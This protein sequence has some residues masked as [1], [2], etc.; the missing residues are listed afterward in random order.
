MGDEDSYKFA[1]YHTAKQLLA[2]YA[3]CTVYPRWVL[4]KNLWGVFQ[5]T[6]EPREEDGEIALY[7]IDVR[8]VAKPGAPKGAPKEKIRT[9]IR[10]GIEDVPFT[11]LRGANVGIVPWC[12]VQRTSDPQERFL[13]EHASE[14]SRYMIDGLPKKWLPQW[15]SAAY[16][17][18]ARVPKWDELSKKGEKC[19]SWFRGSVGPSITPNLERW[20]SLFDTPV[21]ERR[22][23][24]EK[25]V[26]SNRGHIRGREFEIILAGLR[27]EYRPIWEGGEWTPRADRAFRLGLEK[28]AS[29]AGSPAM[30]VAT[31]KFRWPTLLWHGLRSPKRPEINSVGDLPL[32]GVVPDD[33]KI[34]FAAV[35]E[36][37][38]W[39][40]T[41][42]SAEYLDCP[43]LTV[44]EELQKLP[45]Y[46]QSIIIERGLDR[47]AEHVQNILAQS[48]LEWMIGGPF[49]YF[50]AS[51]FDKVFPPEQTIDLAAEY[52]TQ[53]IS[54]RE[55]T[56]RW[57][58]AQAK[59]YR[60]D[61]NKL[62]EPNCKWYLHN[63]QVYAAIW[64]K[65]PEERDLT[66][67]LGSDDGCKVWV[68][69]AQVWKNWVHRGSK[70][71]QDVFPVHL[72]KGWNSVLL[73]VFNRMYGCGF[74]F[75]LRLVDER[76]LPFGDLQFASEPPRGH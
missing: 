62:Y 49:P 24:R 68:N 55:Y 64:V 3:V 51:E 8:E 35:S 70:F 17:N 16:V 23:K 60:I 26:R 1:C 63:A 29:T 34:S 44:T 10:V 7:G 15:Y 61:F 42:W 14:Y 36:S 28:V 13:K 18:Q 27:Q 31:P 37:P 30:A 25:F 47:T 65:C 72:K 21:G 57:Q 73:K 50:Q 32:C 53:K 38:N 52:G 48:E 4:E 58:R 41:V 22:A 66:I 76:L 19:P 74:D 5:Q 12:M 11:D 40:M 56:A 67:A 6:F 9:P 20:D 75:Y 54:R 71:D 69:G 33:T 43:V 59:M 39:G 45:L 46:L 2:L